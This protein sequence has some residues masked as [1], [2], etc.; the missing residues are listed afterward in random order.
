[1]KRNY[2]NGYLPKIA[3]HMVR[4]NQ[5]SVQ[6][7]FECQVESYGPIT[8]ENMTFITQEMNRLQSQLKDFGQLA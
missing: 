2:I 5:N 3:Y 8:P 1:M 4:N 6:Y 7:F